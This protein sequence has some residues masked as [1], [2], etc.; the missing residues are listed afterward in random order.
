MEIV[1]MGEDA[2]NQFWF[3]ELRPLCPFK[4]GSEQYELWHTGYKKE[5]YRRMNLEQARN[6]RKAV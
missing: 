2:F 6:N 4:K 1:D 5:E 3:M